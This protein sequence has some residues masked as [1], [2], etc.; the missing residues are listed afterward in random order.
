MSTVT[1][2]DGCEGVFQ[3]FDS[4]PTKRPKW[5]WQLNI[6]VRTFVKFSLTRQS[7]LQFCEIGSRTL[8]EEKSIRKIEINRPQQTTCLEFCFIFNFLKPIQDGLFQ[9]CSRMGGAKISHTYPTMM[10]LGSYTLPKKD[11]KICRNQSRDKPLEFCWYQHFFN[12]NQQIL[13]Y[14]EI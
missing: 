1:P 7:F 9:G 3:Q 12:G 4:S 8:L 14:Q 10:K 5:K 2:L 6:F 11:P 13:L